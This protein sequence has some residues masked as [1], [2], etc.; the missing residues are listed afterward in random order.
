MLSL[1]DGSSSSCLRFRVVRGTAALA[2]SVVTALDL[3][4]QHI[5]HIDMSAAALGRLPEQPDEAFSSLGVTFPLLQRICCRVDQLWLLESLAAPAGLQQL[6]QL[7]LEMCTC[8]YPLPPGTS[9]STNQNWLAAP[10]EAKLMRCAG[11][12]VWRTL[13]QGTV[14]PV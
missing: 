1:V 9:A 4:K 12:D 6:Q 8:A 14:S 10:S 5:A 11:E 13:T 3:C 2:P 7:H